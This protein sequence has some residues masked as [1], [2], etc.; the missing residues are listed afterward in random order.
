M[1]QTVI[2]KYGEPP[3]GYT[4]ASWLRRCLR[5]EEMNLSDEESSKLLYPKPAHTLDP[6][7]AHTLLSI[8]ECLLLVEK[9]G[10]L[11]TGWSSLDWLRRC[12]RVEDILPEFREKFY[13]RSGKSDL[14]SGGTDSPVEEGFECANAQEW[15]SGRWLD[16]PK[17]FTEE[18]AKSAREVFLGEAAKHYPWEE[19][20]PI[21]KDKWRNVA[22]MMLRKS[23]RV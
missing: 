4:H 18:C 10:D 19:E 11:P 1:G 23:K 3:S 12:Q 22:Q 7:S 6:E 20:E 14:C 2:E 9:F 13:L 21:L 5:L 17:N 16:T 15:F 8:K